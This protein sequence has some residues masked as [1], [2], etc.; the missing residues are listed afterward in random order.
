[1]V[2]QRNIL[3][4]TLKY[5]VLVCA[6]LIILFPLVWMVSV[7]FK[8]KLELF[9]APYNLLPGQINLDNYITA[10]GY[11]P[12]GSY[13]INTIVI[14]FGL[15]FIQLI[16]V[17]MAAF[18]FARM[19]FP[20]KNVLFILF[21]TQL[22]ITAQSTIY[23]NYMTVSKLGMLNTKTGVMLPYIASAMGTFLLRQA[24]MALPTSLED[25]GRIDGC[26]IP[27][28]IIH[29]FLPQVKSALLAFAIMSVTNHWNEFL[30]PLLV[31]EDDN[32]RPLTVGLTIFAQQAEGGAEWSLLMAATLMVS[33]PLL[34]AFLIFQKM[35]VQ[36]F[37]SSGLKG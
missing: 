9:S 1:M 4:T 6:S 22:M 24:F 21:L 13:Y 28:M 29:V 36:A 20:G 8:T 12:F 32:S 18:A 23:P 17:T 11:A 15:L 37:V 16:T 10:W 7:S 2:R 19:E 3:T 27:Q 30:W 26:N 34:L 5:A 33:L 31:T 14:S 25:A 35:F